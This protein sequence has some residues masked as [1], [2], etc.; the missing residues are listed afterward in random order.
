[1]KHTPI[2]TAF[3]IA[4]LWLSSHALGQ[5]VT[6]V[7]TLQDLPE[8]RSF[9]GRIEAVHQATVSAETSGRIEEVRA[10]IGDT[11]AAGTVILT[12]TSTEQRAGL[13]RAEAALAEAE[14]ARVV[15]AAEFQRV[16]G[17]LARQ[18]ASQADMDRVTARLNTAEARADSAAAAL[19][20]AREQLSYTEVRAP[21]AGIVS[22]RMVEPG[23]LVQP[24]TL[25]MS[26]YDPA[27]LRVEVDLPQVVADKVRAI[28]TARVVPATTGESLASAAG[29]AP[30]KLLL[31]PAADAVTSTVRARLE[32]P[33]SASGLYPGQFV[34]VQFTVGSKQG[35]LLPA[36]SVVHRAEV[37]AVYV[38]SDGVPALRQIRVGALVDGQ[39][40]VLAGLAPG[41]HVA[42]DPVAA[43][44]VLTGGQRER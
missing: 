43:A 6:T 27:T 28:G 2:R 14:S 3:A 41:E 8:L 26:G 5:L 10:D 7:A 30:E 17:L 15:E 22:A 16:S 39:L 25:L 35:L 34:D 33:A 38:V 24:G 18:F 21:Y 23:E 42:A 20:T 12:V 29:I 13:T 19:N 9:A 32:L 31:Y 36:T 11:I 37:T 1:M 40:E 4:T 44:L